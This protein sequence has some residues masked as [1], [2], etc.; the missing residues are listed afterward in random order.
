M[1]IARRPAVRLYGCWPQEWEYEQLKEFG[2][3]RNSPDIG[4]CA[5]SRGVRTAIMVRA[6]PYDANQGLGVDRRRAASRAI[7]SFR[8]GS[9]TRLLPC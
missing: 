1:A 3:S 6:Y 9:M 4:W 7:F 5:T 8:S 2:S